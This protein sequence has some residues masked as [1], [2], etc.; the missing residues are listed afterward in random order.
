[1]SEQDAETGPAPSR[2]HRWPWWLAAA[3]VAGVI[4]AVLWT[5]RELDRARQIRNLSYPP[6]APGTNGGS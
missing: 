5:T 6:A 4:L 1:M 3:L 2:R